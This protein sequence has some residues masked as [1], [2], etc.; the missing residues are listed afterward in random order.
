MPDLTGPQRPWWADRDAVQFW[1]EQQQFEATL[2]YFD[3]LTNAIEHQIAYA[4]AD[5]AV[6][7]SDALCALDMI[8]YRPRVVVQAWGGEAVQTLP[9]LKPEPL[10]FQLDDPAHVM[11][12]ACTHPYTDHSDVG[13]SHCPH[14]AGFKYSHDDDRSE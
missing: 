11:V 3:G 9:V 5:P 4:A 7:A 1:C 10:P 12:C 13:C 14:C 2:A 6:A 8:W